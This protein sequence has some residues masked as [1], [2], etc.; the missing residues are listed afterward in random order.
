MQEHNIISL[1]QTLAKIFEERENVKINIIVK[2]K[3][4]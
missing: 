3:E 2:Q 4:N 1:Y